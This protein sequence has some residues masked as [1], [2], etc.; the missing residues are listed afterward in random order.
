MPDHNYYPRTNCERNLQCKIDEDKEN[1][2]SSFINISSSNFNGLTTAKSGAA[3]HLI[4]FCIT[5]DDETTFIICIS[6]EGGGIYIKINEPY[7]DLILIS[8]IVFTGCKAAHG[9][10]AYVYCNQEEGSSYQMK[11]QEQNQ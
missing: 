5:C 3:I 11:Q 4:N 7:D 9:G 8:S 6:S 2:T 1:V 10:A